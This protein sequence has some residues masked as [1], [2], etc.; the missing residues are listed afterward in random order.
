MNLQTTPDPANL[1]P[2]L[3]AGRIERLIDDLAE[4]IAS[5]HAPDAPLMAVAVLKGAAFFAADLVRRLD[6]PVEMEFVRA[7]SYAGT[8]RGPV[9]RVDCDTDELKLRGRD[10]LILDCILDSG[11]TLARLHEIFFAERPAS[12]RSCVLLRKETTKPVCHRADYVGATV[13]DSFLVGY[14]LDHNDLWRHLPY[15]AALPDGFVT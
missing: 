1:K 6:M 11:N 13:A 14:G 4:S 10:V 5:D 9:V 15:V 12:L 8:T 7:R 3:T 2:L